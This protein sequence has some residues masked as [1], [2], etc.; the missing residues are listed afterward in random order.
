M[1]RAALLLILAGCKHSEQPKQD[2]VVVPVASV[3]ATSANAGSPS[4]SVDPPSVPATTGSHTRAGAPGDTRGTIACGHVRCQATHEACVL[5]DGLW[6]CIALDKAPT[7]DRSYECDD[8]SDCTENG[9]DVCCSNDRKS[10]YCG[11]MVPVDS[12]PCEFAACNTDQGAPSCPKGQSC[13]DGICRPPPPRATCTG[14]KQCPAEAPLCLW[15]NGKGTC[16]AADG[17]VD[18]GDAI[19]FECTRPS[20]C[21]PGFT[22][23]APKTGDDLQPTRCQAHCG[24]DREV[25]C[26]RSSD[27]P[28]FY[29]TGANGGLVPQ[30]C[31]RRPASGGASPP[32]WAG[33]CQTP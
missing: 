22:C 17:S 18:A 15:E 21:G 6:V 11:Y 4:A 24:Q 10:A 29:A 20:D 30:A 26:E 28:P 32:A 12:P 5:R 9:N 8:V 1:T 3:K 33:E 14:K 25:V 31:K 16:V 23:C 2:G 27:C 7:A 13:I 19:A